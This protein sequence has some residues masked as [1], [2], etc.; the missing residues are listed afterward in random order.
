MAKTNHDC[1][2]QGCY[3]DRVSKWFEKVIDPCLPGKQE[4]SDID[5]VVERNGRLLLI[6]A[7]SSNDHTFK[8]GQRIL[9]EQATKRG[10]GDIVA[11]VVYRKQG[12]IGGPREGE[13]LWCRM[14]WKGKVKDAEE[15]SIEQFQDMVKRWYAWADCQ[16]R[17]PKPPTT[18]TPVSELTADEINWG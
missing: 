10:S 14:V 16:A 6:E 2:K 7:K 9:F 11:I 8:G 17:D 18:T 5:Y 1:N 13:V 4:G 15:C 12:M 3:L